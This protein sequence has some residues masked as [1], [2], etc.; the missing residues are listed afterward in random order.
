MVMHVDSTINDQ[1]FRLLSA[2]VDGELQ[3]SVATILEQRLAQ[4][5]ELR[6]RLAALQALQQQLQA[7][8]VVDDPVPQR[9]R[10]L[11]Q[12]QPSRIRSVPHRLARFTGYA[13]QGLA[14][15]A[16][17]AAIAGLLLAS[18][19]QRDLEYQN[20]DT[21]LAAALETH[22]S[23]AEGWD[24]L[25]DG[26]QLRTVLSFPGNDGNWCREYILAVD[27]H[28]IRGVACR[29][30]GT[31]ETRVSAAETLLP[32]SVEAT[33]RP[34]SAGDSRAIASFIEQ[35]AGGNAAGPGEEAGLIS[36]NW[37]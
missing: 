14:V 34:A 24:T 16:S 19:W 33:Y 8:A 9:V 35:H 6:A 30:S 11:L 23:R 32:G 25:D 36:N 3:L 7:A 1:D 18:Q 28:A 21:M 31:W 2:Y 13:R 29:D 20:G 37:Q 4:E 27:G 17:L 12:P 10:E 26:R 15:A 22:P 5:P